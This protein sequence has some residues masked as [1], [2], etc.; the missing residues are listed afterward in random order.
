MYQWLENKAFNMASHCQV[1]TEEL[2]EWVCSRYKIEKNKVSVVPNYVNTL[3]FAPAEDI[4][5]RE[6][7][8][9]SVGRLDPVKRF[10]VLIKACAKIS[11]CK[12]TIVGE[13]PEKN[14]L[15]SL[16]Q[17]L[18][19]NLNLIGNISNEGLPELLNKH[20]IYAVTS[21]W[22]G[23]PKALIEAMA[24]GKPTVGVD[25]LGINS[26]IRHEWNGLLCD[27]N[28]ETIAS[29]MIRLFEE[30]KLRKE[31]SK[32]AATFI[33]SKYDHKIVFNSEMQILENILN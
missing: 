1:P 12:L 11:D 29:A 26:I 14:N 16:A 20:S 2:A 8:V 4:Q 31:I 33:R 30:D 3:I 9:I 23:N 15:K 7:S 25:V 32:N 28:S 18:E 24:C 17:R 10:S 13:G 6:K 22:E 5:G 27:S 19:V 21:K